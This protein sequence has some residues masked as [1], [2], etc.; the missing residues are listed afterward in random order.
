MRILLDRGRLLLPGRLVIEHL[1]VRQW[2]LF[3]DVINDVGLT[4]NMLAPLFG[5]VRALLPPVVGTHTPP[6]PWLSV[7]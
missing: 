2:R 6:P 1:H 5:K 3:A 7:L 4:L